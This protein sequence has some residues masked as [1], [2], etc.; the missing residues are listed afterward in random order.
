[1]SLDPKQ[2]LVGPPTVPGDSAAGVGD[3][4]GGGIVASGVAVTSDVGLADGAT[5]ADTDALTRGELCCDPQAATS[6]AATRQ[7]TIT[8]LAARGCARF[9]ARVEPRIGIRR[10]GT[11]R[12][13]ARVTC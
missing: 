6:M 13:R 3:E 2:V 12:Q 1:M 4:V 9:V 11:I 5:E 10:M 7:S 8:G